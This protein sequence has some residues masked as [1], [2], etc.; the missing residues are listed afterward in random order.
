MTQ[1]ISPFFRAGQ[2]FT[3]F[4]AIPA[5]LSDSVNP[6]AITT[7]VIF[8]ALLLNLATSHK[9]VLIVGSAFIFA[10]FQFTLLSLLGQFD[11][12]F[13]SIEVQFLLKKIYLGLAGVFLLLG[14]I[15]LYEWYLLRRSN[16]FNCL[17]IRWPK[18]FFS[19]E[20]GADDLNIRG[21]S[22]FRKLVLIGLG[23]GILCAILETVWPPHFF[24]NAL[25]YDFA[26]AGKGFSVFMAW[27]MYSLI[28]VLPLVLALA[29]VYFASKS[30]KIQT[31]QAGVV[32]FKIISAAVFISLG[33][34]LIYVFA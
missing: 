31:G 15:H 33:I 6:T 9:S 29:L 32:R 27:C 25:Y 30:G 10:V 7:L 16:S 18:F 34:G 11:Q 3:V 22:F 20:Q 5:G 21:K 2:L 26:F 8:I 1:E 17:I 28:F 12:S 23:A 14:V 4:P 19:E 24:I 13:L